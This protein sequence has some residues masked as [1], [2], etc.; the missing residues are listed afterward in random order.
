MTGIARVRADPDAPRACVAGSMEPAWTAGTLVSGSSARRMN[1]RQNG[2]PP[3]PA[4]A[5]ATSSMVRPVE[6]DAPFAVRRAEP[7]LLHVCMPRAFECVHLR[8]PINEVTDMSWWCPG[9]AVTGTKWTIAA[10]R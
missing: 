4:L 10:V 5:P 2:R 6:G 8:P 7:K 9:R 3:L 1:A